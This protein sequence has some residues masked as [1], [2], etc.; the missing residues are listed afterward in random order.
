MLDSISSEEL[1][2]WAAYYRLDPFGSYRADVQAGIVASVIANVNAKKGHSFTPS[3]FIP[4]FDEADGKGKS[5]GMSP[6][7]IYN[8]LAMRFGRPTRG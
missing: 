4:R 1:T 6:K 3:D 7:E 2:E 5:K 8:N